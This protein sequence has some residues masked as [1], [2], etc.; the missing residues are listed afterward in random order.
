MRRLTATFLNLLILSLLVTAQQGRFRITKDAQP[1]SARDFRFTISGFS[2]GTIFL[3]DDS[4]ATLSNSRLFVGLPGTY[5]VTEDQADS[6]QLANISC[7]ETVAQN[8]T[9]NVLTRTATII[10]EDTEV[11]TCIFTNV[12]PSSGEARISGRISTQNDYGISKAQVIVTDLTT[13]IS[14]TA[15]SNPFGYY[16][17]AGVRAGSFYRISVK[18]KRHQFDDLFL[19]IVDDLTDTNFIAIDR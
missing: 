7:T 8:S 5:T 17:I 3:D 6:W 16:S 9:T 12:L 2:P 18:H 10:V 15:V 11:V 13:N 14:H 19:T 4:D 1:N